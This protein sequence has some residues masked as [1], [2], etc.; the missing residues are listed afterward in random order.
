MPQSRTQRGGEWSHSGFQPGGSRTKRPR[1]SRARGL[2]WP[3]RPPRCPRR[4]REGSS[5]VLV[6]ASIA[7]G[8][9]LA[10]SSE[11]SKFSSADAALAMPS[12]ARARALAA[13]SLARASSPHTL[14]S[15]S[16]AASS[17]AAA[18]ASAMRLVFCSSRARSQARSSASR[19]RMSKHSANVRAVPNRQHIHR[20]RKLALLRW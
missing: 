14:R 8:S 17:S 6:I 12:S 15:S 5:V 18:E 7:L 2:P 4:R 20:R 13:P 10:S 19:H 9:A 1:R 11:G 3:R 16:C